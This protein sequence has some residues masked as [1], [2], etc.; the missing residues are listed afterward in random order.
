MCCKLCTDVFLV[1]FQKRKLMKIEITLAN[2][3]LWPDAPIYNL[4]GFLLRII[5]P[6]LLALPKTYCFEKYNKNDS[7]IKVWYDVAAKFLLGRFK[8]DLLNKFDR[9]CFLRVR[10]NL[11]Q[12]LINIL[13]FKNSLWILFVFYYF[14]AES[15][16]I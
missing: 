10:V 5:C 2:L 6:C 1:C 3:H 4:F 11:C 15:I 14:L 9:S 12:K 13:F 8:T 7:L 16:F